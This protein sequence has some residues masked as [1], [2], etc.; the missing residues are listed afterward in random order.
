MLV[1][2]IGRCHLHVHPDVV[3]RVARHIMRAGEGGSRADRLASAIDVRAPLAD[4]DRAKAQDLVGWVERTRKPASSSVAT[5][6][7][8]WDS[9]RSSQPTALC[10]GAFTCTAM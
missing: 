7:G 3:E 9:L 5:L 4:D 6:G 1:G 2:R 8:Y 10:Q